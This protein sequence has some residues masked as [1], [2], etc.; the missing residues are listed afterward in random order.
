MNIDATRIL[1]RCPQNPV[2]DVKDYPGIAQLYNPSPVK[3]G[4]ETIVLVSVVEHAGKH[5]I[6]R[7]VGQTRVAR[8]KDGIESTG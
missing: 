6:G 2:I 5:G 4:D 7:D 8:S 1:T 3:L